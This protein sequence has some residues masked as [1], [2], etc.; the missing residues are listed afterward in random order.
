MTHQLCQLVMAIK[1]DTLASCGLC[2]PGMAMP[3]VALQ[4]QMM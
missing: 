2:R 4:P 1:E 3:P